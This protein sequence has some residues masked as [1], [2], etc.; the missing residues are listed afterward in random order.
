MS[1]PLEPDSVKAEILEI[2]SAISE[3]ATAEKKVEAQYGGPPS[4][5]ETRLFTKL[6]SITARTEESRI[7]ATD[8]HEKTRQATLAKFEQE[9]QTIQ[10]QYQAALHDIESR[11]QTEKETAEREK[12]D[13]AWM[14]SSV[15]DDQSQD[16]P[17]FQYESFSK[18]LT[19]TKEK[20]RPSQRARRSDGGSRRA[21]AYRRRQ[22]QTFGDPDPVTPPRDLEECDKRFE[23]ASMVIFRGKNAL[24]AQKLSRLFTSW[25]PA[26]MFL[27]TWRRRACR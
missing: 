7:K 24:I 2:I 21:H 16:S 20:M 1:Q 4:D 14:V 5:A 6:R 3:R 8:E 13:A 26:V 27:L 23:D 18:R 22:W 15:L 12:S 19:T 25:M 9:H 10:S 17:R 11:F